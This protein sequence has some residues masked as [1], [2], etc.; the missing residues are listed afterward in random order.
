MSSSFLSI[1][2][3]QSNSSDAV[4][5]A[6]SLE[7]DRG[8]SKCVQSDRMWTRVPCLSTTESYWHLTK[9]LPCSSTKRAHTHMSVKHHRNKQT[10][11]TYVWF[12]CRN[13]VCKKGYLLVCC[14]FKCLETVAKTWIYRNTKMYCD[15]SQPSQP[16]QPSQ[17]SNMRS[18]EIKW[19]QLS[20]QF[21]AMNIFQ[22][23]LE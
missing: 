16:S 2:E 23:L 18:V 11:C 6:G 21:I 8:L 1:V 3:L 14:A 9:L 7:D 12:T 4:T 20:H 5:V 22:A 15:T 10:S 13:N 17:Q 19:S